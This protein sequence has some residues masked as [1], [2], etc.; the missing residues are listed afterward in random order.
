MCD[1]NR[2]EHNILLS[3]Q[4]AKVSAVQ[5]NQNYH[6]QILRILEKILN[7]KRQHEIE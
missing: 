5:Q 7:G 1:V 3:R 4:K 6:N 2:T